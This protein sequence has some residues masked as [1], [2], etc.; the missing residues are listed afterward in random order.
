MTTVENIVNNLTFNAELE[1]AGKAILESLLLAAQKTEE[2][3]KIELMNRIDNKVNE[4]IPVQKL[5]D[6]KGMVDISVKNVSFQEIL[7]KVQ[8]DLYPVLEDTSCLVSKIIP[9]LFSYSLYLLFNQLDDPSKA[10]TRRYIFT[11]RTAIY[12]L[13]FNICAYKIPCPSLLPSI[14]SVYCIVASQSMVDINRIDFPSLAYFYQRQLTAHGIDE[15]AL[16][17]LF[18]ELKSTYYMLKSPPYNPRM[19]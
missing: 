18:Q 15:K 19:K 9:H 2:L 5:V 16:N 7:K 12:M 17:F 14:N 10:I 3:Y 11:D 1:Q 8:L 6:L 4:K 13:E